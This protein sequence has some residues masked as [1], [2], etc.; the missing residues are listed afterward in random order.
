MTH[1]DKL[2][3]LRAVIEG[4]P[5]VGADKRGPLILRSEALAAISRLEGH[6]TAMEALDEIVAMLK[7]EAGNDDNG[8]NARRVFEY[9]YN[10][11]V[12]LQRRVRP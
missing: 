12:E 2:A 10:N 9:A 6:L 7:K 1:D 3:E 4:I 8:L 5:S 11:A